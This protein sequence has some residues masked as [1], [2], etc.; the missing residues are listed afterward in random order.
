MDWFANLVISAVEGRDDGDNLEFMV[1]DDQTQV[2]EYTDQFRQLL[3]VEL[4]F[5]NAVCAPSRTIM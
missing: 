2:T 5:L 4:S 1:D 3:K